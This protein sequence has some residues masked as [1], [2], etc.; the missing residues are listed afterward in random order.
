LGNELVPAWSILLCSCVK[1]SDN[2]YLWID[3]CDVGNLSGN[4]LVLG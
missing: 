2:T 3:C 1:L 4:L